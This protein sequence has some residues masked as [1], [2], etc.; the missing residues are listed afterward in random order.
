MSSGLARGVLDGL[1]PSGRDRGLGRTHNR[2]DMS[3]LASRTSLREHPDARA[4]QGRLASPADADA[5]AYPSARSSRGSR[6]PDG[7]VRR[8]GDAGSVRGRDP[9]APGGA[10]RRRRLR[11]LAHGR[12]RGGRPDRARP[13]PGHALERRRQAPGRPGPVLADHE[14]VGRDRRRRDRLPPRRAPLPHRRERVEP[15]GGLRLAQGAR[16]ARLRR[17]RRLRRVRAPRR[18]RPACAR[19]ARAR[20]GHAVHVRARRARRRRGDDQPHRVHRRGGRRAR[21]HGRG[22]RAPLG[23]DPRARRRALRARR[24]RHAA[25]RGLLP[26]ARKRHRPGAGRDLV[27]AR[28]GVRARD[29]VHRRRAAC[30]RSRSTAPSRSS[31]RS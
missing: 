28:L 1:R 18:A 10:H 22:R 3:A 17:P 7:P 4:L 24:A 5:P 12:A 25:A 16:A 27:G 8:L 15:R 19:A 23:R 6:R 26:A 9:G 31:C 11:R 13:A 14:R 29:R 2:R 21:L 30:A 20:E